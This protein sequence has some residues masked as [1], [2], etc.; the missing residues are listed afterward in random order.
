MVPGKDSTPFLENITKQKR[1]NQGNPM[2]EEYVNLILDSLL[3]ELDFPDGLVEEYLV[4]KCI[5]KSSNK[6]MEIVGIPDFSKLFPIHSTKY[7]IHQ[8]DYLFTNINRVHKP[9]IT[10]NSGIYRLNRLMAPNICCLLISF[11]NQIILI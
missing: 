11:R 8:G 2:E 3:Y 4:I 7:E 5:E 10:T 9:I 6:C 1:Y